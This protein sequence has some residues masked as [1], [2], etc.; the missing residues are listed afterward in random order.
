MAAV[1]ISL[2]LL[3]FGITASYNAHTTTEFYTHTLAQAQV[4]ESVTFGAQT[5]RVV[6][7]DVYLDGT[8]VTGTAALPM[9][10]LAYEVTLARRSPLLALPGTDPVEL[11][12]AT[13][14]LVE[15]EMRLAAL[16]SNGTNAKLVTRLYPVA[17]LRRAADLEEARQ[18]LL[19][20]PTPQHARSYRML[21][22]RTLREKEEA[23]QDFTNAFASATATSTEHIAL[24]S[25]VLSST[26][27][28]L[29]LD[30]FTHN[31]SRERATVAAR[32][33]CSTGIVRDCSVLPPAT[34]PKIATTIDETPPEL[35]REIL[36]LWG[37]VFSTQPPAY[38]VV[39]LPNSVC[40]PDAGPVYVTLSTQKHQQDTY[41]SLT[42]VDDLLF[43]DLS[44]LADSGYV[45]YMKK[46]YGMRY[47]PINPFKFYIC[48]QIGIDH[49]TAVA[50]AKL[51]S[52]T[53]LH[54]SIEQ[55]GTDERHQLEEL[56][57]MMRMKTGGLEDIVK[58]IVAITIANTQDP[59]NT[60]N[61]IQA[62]YEFLT[63]SA[64]ATFFRI[65]APDDTWLPSLYKEDSDATAEMK[66]H[67][68][69]YSSLRAQVPRNTIIHD[70]R[71]FLMVENKLASTTPNTAPPSKRPMVV[72]T[73]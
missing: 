65:G 16:Q 68:K 59:L 58:D 61:N 63:H 38:T 31:L 5:Y 3:L 69:T 54:P 41:T 17:F 44:K 55:Y 46:T 21:I 14:N 50:T 49:G 11:R 60:L 36:A 25:G 43:Y 9:L 24:F 2:L 51:A 72:P 62:P 57:L 26:T 29:V 23:L 6:G 1:A 34:I 32:I 39:R 12:A 52:F 37:S 30:T 7:G 40:L 71:S 56:E 13:T 10:K 53:K 42:R 73:L 67:I 48:A 4:K 20:V 28:R 70:L 18:T 47:S 22:S 64:F 45:A 15:I 19:A 35:T 27:V 8:K 33:R 66:V